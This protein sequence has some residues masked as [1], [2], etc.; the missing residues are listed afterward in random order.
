MAMEFKMSATE[1][2][3]FAWLRAEGRI[4]RAEILKLRQEGCRLSERPEIRFIILDLSGGAWLDPDAVELLVNTFILCRRKGGE[5]TIVARAKSQPMEAL[6]AG[7]IGQIVSLFD[8]AKA[9]QEALGLK[10]QVGLPEMRIECRSQA[11]SSAGGALGAPG[12]ER[13]RKLEEVEEKVRRL[14]RRIN[15]LESMVKESSY[16]YPSDYA[17]G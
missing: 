6:K 16:Y 17:R 5:M 12:S 13:A 2:P 8:E 4:E 3:P 1:Q 9:A 10:Y 7:A 15:L 14:E 11:A